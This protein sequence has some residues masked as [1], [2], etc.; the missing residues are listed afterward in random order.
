MFEK[1]IEA[2]R[3]FKPG[4]KIRIIEMDGEPERPDGGGY[5]GRGGPVKY[6]DAAGQ[7][8]GTWGWLA[9]QPDRDTIEKLED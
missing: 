1:R 6:S 9:V 7:L 3:A 2:A 8:H 4:D 5:A